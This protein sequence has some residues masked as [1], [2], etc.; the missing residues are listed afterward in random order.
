MQKV[1]EKFR[2][3]WDLIHQSAQAEQIALTKAAAAAADRYSN[4]LADLIGA[5]RG[6]ERPDANDVTVIGPYTDYQFRIGPEVKEE[7]PQEEEAPAEK[8]LVD[9]IKVG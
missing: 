5:L 7:E 4:Q 3:W 9:G 1:P 6:Q 2:G 8:V